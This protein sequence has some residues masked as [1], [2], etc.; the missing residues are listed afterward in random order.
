[1]SFFYYLSRNTPH[2]RH[3]SQNPSGDEDDESFWADVHEVLQGSLRLLADTTRTV[4]FMNC[5]TVFRQGRLNA[6]ALP[7]MLRKLKFLD[8]A[9][10]GGS[11]GEILF[12]CARTP[13]VDLASF[14]AMASW[15]A[16]RDAV[17][18]HVETDTSRRELFDANSLPREPPSF[19]AG[20]APDAEDLDLTPLDEVAG[21]EAHKWKDAEQEAAP[22]LFF[23]RNMLTLLIMPALRLRLR[24]CGVYT[25]RNLMTVDPEDEV[26]GGST[27]TSGT[28]CVSS[29]VRNVA[30]LLHQGV[31]APIP[32][33]ADS[34]A[35][36]VAEL[37]LRCATAAR[38]VDILPSVPATVNR[39]ITRADFAAYLEDREADNSAVPFPELIMMQS[40][41][42][43]GDCDTGLEMFL[44]NFKHTS[45]AQKL[46]IAI[47]LTA[48][49]CHSASHCHDKLT[50]EHDQPAQHQPCHSGFV[51]PMSDCPRVRTTLHCSSLPRNDANTMERRAWH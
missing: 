10:A 50:Y 35:A 51:S 49:T 23:I 40:W 37:V 15:K 11:S 36:H 5:C 34:L 43:V 25:V 17:L 4:Y 44:T 41:G 39:W 46:T 22:L 33:D 29:I 19:A 31:C 42:D 18:Q 9:L 32:G 48:A 1:M 24:L 13:S 45:S 2:R 14:D 16:A 30:R 12:Y 8:S 28:L 7:P 38:R 26:N 3:A 47:Q 21:S 27:T 20:W 6:E